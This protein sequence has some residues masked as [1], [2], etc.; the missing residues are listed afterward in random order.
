[1]RLSIGSRIRL[2]VAA[3]AL[4]FA[5]CVL[6]TFRV[7]SA[8]Q[9]DQAIQA[10]GEAVQAALRLSIR[11]RGG[12]QAKLTRFLATTPRV[13]M[14]A[15]ADKATAL[16]AIGGLRENAGVDGILLLGSGG[17]PLAT[18]GLGEVDSV[19]E[20]VHGQ[21]D[22]ALKGVPSRG[23]V[24]ADGDPMLV[25]SEPLR[26]DAYVHG[27]VVTF[28]RMDRAMAT[29]LGKN[30]RG[31][32][33]FFHGDRVLGSSLP[34]RGLRL[35]GRETTQ[36]VWVNG[37]PYIAR[38]APMPGAAA[39]DRLGVVTL[40]S[41]DDATATYRELAS[42]FMAVLAVVTLTALLGG[43]GFSRTITR[44]LDAVV[45]AARVMQRGEWPRRFDS[46]RKDEV[47]LLQNVFDDM[48]IAIQRAQT[49]L[50]EMI[51]RDPLTKLDNHRSFKQRLDQEV[52]RA[53]VSG[54][55]LALILLDLDRFGEF[56]ESHGH[57]EGDRLL[58]GVAAAIQAQSPEFAIVARYGADAFAVLVSQSDSEAI[59]GLMERYGTV[60]RERGTTAS[61]GAAQYLLHAQESAGF[62]LAAEL[63]LS[64][65]QQ[66]GGDRATTFDAFQVAG[67]GTDPYEVSRFMRDASLATIQA[68]AAA[69]DA[70]DPYTKG[71][72]TRVAEMGRDLCAYLGDGPEHVDRIYRSGTLHDVGKIGV[73]DAILKKPARL[74]EEERR[75][76]ETHPV[77]GEII[78][79]KVPQL[80][81][82]LPGVRHHHEAYDGKGY[83][84]GLAGD[85]IPRMARILAVV[86]TYDAMTS[87][88]PYRK[89]LPVEVALSE[90]SKG[91]G[92]QFDPEMAHA[93]CAM[94]RSELT[95]SRAA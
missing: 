63:A 30:V 34:L 49:E 20:S 40:R 48:S 31:E 54:G 1:M 50:L 75:I 3:L 60:A 58:Q 6:A 93:F 69:V 59:V 77:L 11:E 70:K 28:L 33:A 89:G 62:A 68:L 42:A 72:S 22:K 35:D 23:I 92:T 64:R 7:L 39:G 21:T 45:A 4:G 66:L 51:D 88:R 57:A 36:T 74:E 73:P 26:I 95:L 56:N 13:T 76:M 65:A 24:E 32:V 81:D 10:D 79:R 46:R 55:D 5:V 52:G 43:A 25:A 85:E 90:I 27:A 47:G 94:I 9:A 86:D 87:D 8:R 2:L 44:P 53:A 12:L 14:L 19:L 61:V 18:S 41:V 80:E 38:I 29:V 83:P 16:D 84:D 17:K 15:L 71:H 91:A 37:A 78:V 67:E 82:L